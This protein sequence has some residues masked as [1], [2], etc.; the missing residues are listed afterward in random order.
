MGVVW[1]AHDSRLHRDVALKVLPDGLVADAEA[2]A[3]LV[4]EARAAAALSHPHILTVHDVAESDGH[5]CVV[6]ELVPGRP[7]SELIPDGGM[8][9]PQVLRLGRQIAAALGHAHARGIVHRDVK[10]SNVLVTPAG[11]AKVLDFGIALRLGSEIDD[12]RSIQLTAPGALLGTPAAMAPELW[13][14]APAD[15]RSDV[16]AL[17][18]LLYTMLTGGPPYRAASPPALAAA[19]SGSDPPPLP[20]RVPAALR[21]VVARCLARDPGRRYASAAAVEAA[22]EAIGAGSHTARAPRP[23]RVA[24]IATGAVLVVTLSAAIAWWTTHRGVTPGN[25]ITSLA[26]L[27]LENFSRDPE[28]QYFADGMTEELITRLAQLGV[29]RV[30]SRTSSMRFRGSALPLPEIGRQLGVDAIVEGSVQQAGGRVRI[31]AQL[32]R[33]ARDEHL[34][35]QSYERETGDALAL[36]D[37]VAGAIAREVG[38]ALAPRPAPA[39]GG[40][41]G[42]A[43]RSPADAARHA[44][45]IQAY[46]RGRDAYQRWTVTGGRAAIAYYDQALALDST[47]T[48]ALTARATA[49]LQITASPETT[50]LARAAIDVALARDPGIGEAHAAHAKLL[51]ENDWNWPAAEQEF[52]RAIA[53]NPNDV[54][55]HHHYSH[56][57]VA[58][59]RL[60]EAREQARIMLSLDP[61]APAG[62]DHMGWLEYETGHLDQAIA[63]ERQALVLDR[64]YFVAYSQ[65]ADALLAGRRWPALRALLDEARGA[66]DRVDPAMFDL[67]NAAA[68]GRRED[69]A[70]ALRVIASTNDTFLVFW[71]QVAGWYEALGLREPAFAAIDSAY[72]HHDYGLMFYNQD[73]ALTGLRSDPRYGA[74]RRRMH[75][76]S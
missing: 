51:F 19:I 37:E 40:I 18:A 74:M 39:P 61:L 27:P 65:I 7:L 71:S 50:T 2:R 42:T 28:Q 20:G 31:S 56:L 76:P 16:W 73:P 70:R 11:D 13:G 63:E 10:P 32:V 68:R 24:A 21:A 64:G 60:A 58:L 48:Q 55:A 22:L 49:L 12:T 8:P 44:A 45:A 36:Q 5:V 66:G 59:G 26:V 15:T 35:A 1:R 46:L 57:L 75:L 34:W 6:M 67:V 14:G 17:G 23:R 69:G 29:V 38:G 30:I 33:A 41:A 47:F 72:A 62:H 9:V 54:D 4:R 53:L 25:R 43:A 52:R 3:R